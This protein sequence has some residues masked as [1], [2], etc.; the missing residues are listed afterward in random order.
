[1]N[2]ILLRNESIISICMHGRFIW[3]VRHSNIMHGLFIDSPRHA[4]GTQFLASIKCVYDND[5]HISFYFICSTIFDIEMSYFVEF[6]RILSKALY[7][8]YNIHLLCILHT[9]LLYPC[10]QYTF[11]YV[12][13]IFFLYLL[14]K[15]HFIC[16]TN[17]ISNNIY[18][19]YLQP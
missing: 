19:L 10:I 1:M 13:N 3:L 14:D 18:T 9:L 6:C 15:V 17:F 8:A 12:Y 16:F 5:F 2:K 4:H 11:Y 7:T